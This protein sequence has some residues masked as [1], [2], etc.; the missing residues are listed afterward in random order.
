MLLASLNMTQ[1]ICIVLLALIAVLLLI[2]PK[3]IWKAIYGKGG[4]VEPDGVTFRVLR[5]LGVLIL[6]GIGYVCWRML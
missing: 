3:T 4:G 2:S 5:A 1:W 6:I